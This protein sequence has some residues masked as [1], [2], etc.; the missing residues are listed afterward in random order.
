MLKAVRE[1]LRTRSEAL[2]KSFEHGLDGILKA[3]LFIAMMACS[4]RVA[5]AGGGIEHTGTPSF[6]SYLLLVLAPVVS[7]TLALRWFEAANQAPRSSRLTLA[8]RWR[9]VSADEARA[10][11]L[12]GTSGIMVSLLLGMLL[13]VPVRA[14]EYLTAM[15]PIPTDA[16]RWASVLQTAM[17]V[18]V[19]LFTSLYPIAFVAALKKSP[20]FPRL[21]AGIWIADVGMQLVIAKAVTWATLLPPTVADALQSLL[22][23]NV[24]K[25]LISVCLWLPYLLLSTRVNVTYRQRVPA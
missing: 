20:W 2:L 10:H 21:L 15:P 7:T 8:G 5:A 9:D 22:M 19:V 14:L 4:A 3:W 12:Y 13:N 6:V 11:H 17:T 24:K 1:R 18:D 25:V 23:G 16:P